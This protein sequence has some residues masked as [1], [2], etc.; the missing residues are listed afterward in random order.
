MSVHR[1]TAGRPRGQGM[2]VLH[3]APA[4]SG[5]GAPELIC[6]QVRT[7][8]GRPGCREAGPGGTHTPGGRLPGTHM[9]YRGS[10]AGGS[11]APAAGV[12]L[13]PAWTYPPSQLLHPARRRAGWGWA[14]T[15]VE[16]PSLPSLQRCL[17]LPQTPRPVQG[18]SSGR[19]RQGSVIAVVTGR[20]RVRETCVPAVPWAAEFARAFADL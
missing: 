17:L 2:R 13:G 6:I 11:R 16:L 10:P 3:A 7:Q 12:P 14:V 5:L 4:G 19:L 18:T 8:D 9:Q 15:P 1:T 20:E